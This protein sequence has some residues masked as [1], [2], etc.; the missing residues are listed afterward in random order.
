MSLHKQQEY[1]KGLFMYRDPEYISN[2]YTRPPTR[3]SNSG[4]CQLS[5]PRPRIDI[6]NKHNN[7]NILYSSQQ[8]IKAVVRSYTL[9]HNE[10]L[11]GT[12]LNNSKLW[13]THVPTQS[14]YAKALI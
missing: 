10:E 3:Y 7:S 5:L 11:N 2:M 13:N 14:T 1:N 9:T 12:Y 4:N 6:Q 8:E